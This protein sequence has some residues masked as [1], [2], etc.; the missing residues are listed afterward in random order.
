[1]IINYLKLPYV[2]FSGAAEDTTALGH[3]TLNMSHSPSPYLSSARHP[4]PSRRSHH[5]ISL[6]PHHASSSR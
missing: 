2:T 5:L 4:Y 1:M 3:D 6:P